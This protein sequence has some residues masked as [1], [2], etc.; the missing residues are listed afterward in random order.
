M[1][2][3]STVIW[4]LVAASITTGMVAC[5]KSGGGNPNYNTGGVGVANSYPPT[6]ISS[7]FYA[8]NT[9]MDNQYQNNGTSYN[10][11]QGMKDVLKYAMGVCDRNSVDAGLAG[12]N[13]WMNNAFHDI[14]LFTQSTQA[15][16]VSLVI[17]ALPD[18]TCTNPYYCSWY[19]LSL[20]SL[21]Q[22]FLSWFGFNTFNMSGVYN[23]LVLTTTINPICVDHDGVVCA[24][25]PSTFSTGFELRSYG[26]AGATY[27]QGGNLLFQ[28]QVPVGK[29]E[30]NSWDFNLYFNSSLAGSGRMVRCSTPN[31]GVQGL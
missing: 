18:T 26:P 2:K 15:N 25:Q 9:K 21:S 14:M 7:G 20:P 6:A 27:H 4:V 1:K 10:L 17:R 24:D 12:C 31:C 16:Q 23:P 13:A 3:L 22:F 5:G 19:S 8:Q 11:G 30:D 29:L 28:F